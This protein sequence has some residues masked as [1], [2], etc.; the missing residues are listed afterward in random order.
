MSQLET[1]IKITLPD[2][3]QK[4]LSA[5]TTG[6]DLAGSISSRL[7][8]EAVGMLSNGE[9][10]D[11]NRPLEHGANIKILTEKDP[12]SLE[13]LRHSTAHIMA[14]AVQQLF[15]EAKIAIGPTIEN[16]FYYDFDIAN[17]QLTPQD[18]EKIE[19][20]MRE[21]AS[22]KQ[23]FV[24]TTIEDVDKQLIEFN[25]H[26][27]I[28]KAELLNEKRDNHPTLYL[29]VNP[30]TNETEWNDF[31]RGPHLP[32]TSF[33]KVFKLLS[34]A[35][36][37]WRGNEKNK[38]LQRIYA[39]CFFKQKDL[40]HY[41]QQIEEAE[42]RDHRKL[43]KQ[44]DLF[45]IQDEVGP[46]L[47]LWHPNA[48]LLREELENYWRKLHRKKGYQLVY[49]PHIAK[50]DLWEISG[51]A[52]FY[53]QNMFPLEI[54]DEDY[55]LKPMNCPFHVLIFKS[56]LRSY[57]DLPIRLGELGTVY[58]YEKSGAM[59]GLTRVRGFTQDDAHLF[60]RPDQIASE[61]KGVLDIVSE[62]FG[63]FNMAY[64]V[65]LS[66]RPEEFVGEIDVWDQAEAALQQALNDYGVNYEINPG[67]GAFYG[68]KIDFK[69]RDA[70]NRVWQCA[71]IQVDFNLPQRFGIKYK[72][73]DGMDKQPVMIHR[74]IFGSM[75]RF[76]ATLIEHYGG[77]F[78]AWL[79]P[80]QVAI[81]TIADRHEEKAQRYKAQLEDF[82]IRVYLDN[83]NEGVG[84]KIR[85]GI[86]QKYPYLLIVGDKEVEQNTVSIRKYPD[87][88][89]GSRPF[90]RFLT[91]LA[92]EIQSY[93]KQPI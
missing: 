35:G 82:N 30:A 69:V 28:Y 10:V 70:L 8:K 27:E 5:G 86:L 31:C 92:L 44:L 24:R 41:L 57:R 6:A 25:T 77:A 53:W 65:E 49:C 78:P 43:G 2:G 56:Q 39:T 52:D 13:I 73:S 59:H 63:M 88:D 38:M 40:D 72:D 9:I 3:S 58:R 19:T 34:V 67:D 1:Q 61:I 55:V 50:K 60:C 11:L 84:H 80:T 17:H 4:E 51:H 7:L 15:P 18:L 33:I 71:T 75:E 79:A 48:A 68:P 20:K 46:G 54:E 16:G 21:I 36:A 12:E 26:G 62:T 37:Y 93:G 32:D 66:T 23:H 87:G 91:E 47:V 89:L 42:K 29:C 64:D 76:V 81:L 90:E 74:A 83:R 85:D 14:Q 22:K 45:S